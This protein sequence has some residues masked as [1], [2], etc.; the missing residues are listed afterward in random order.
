M[1][2]LTDSL[3]DLFVKSLPYKAGRF[4]DIGELLIRGVE[5][6][7]KVGERVLHP[8]ARHQGAVQLTT[9]APVV[10]HEHRNQQAKSLRF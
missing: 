1:S 8:L 4:H 5:P 9:P 2:S 10:N 3:P 6:V 7:L